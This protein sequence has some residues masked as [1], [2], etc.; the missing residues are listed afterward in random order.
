MKRIW[1]LVMVL[2]MLLGGIGWGG[3]ALAENAGAAAAASGDVTAVAVGVITTIGA[4]LALILAWLTW[5]FIIPWVQTSTLG[6]WADIAV[7][8]MEA[9]IGSGNG[10]QKLA[11]AT[12]MVMNALTRLHLHADEDAIYAALQAAWQK[13][14]LSQ[15]A[16]GVKEAAA[17]NGGGDAGEVS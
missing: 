15:I 4:A 2:L 13:L 5:K 7:N 16:A 9:I 6:K 14:N 1:I 8:A 17:D 10:D 12:D 11:G 3:S